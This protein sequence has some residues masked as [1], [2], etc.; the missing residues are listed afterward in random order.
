MD[1]KLLNLNTLNPISGAKLEFISSKNQTLEEGTTN[2]N[3]KY[4]SKTNL[5]NVFYV[6]VKYGNEFNVLYLAGNKIN[7]S[8]FDIGGSLQLRSEERRVG[9]ECRSRWSPYH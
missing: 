9:K 6:F 2:S 5:D 7:Y 1:L 8:D 4:K 3:G